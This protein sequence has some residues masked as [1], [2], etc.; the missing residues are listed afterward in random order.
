MRK[1]KIIVN[2]IAGR[3]SGEASI[4]AIQKY[5]NEYQLDFELERTEHPGHAIEIAYR[6]ASEDYYAVVAVGGDGTANEVLNGLVQV[7]NE[8]NK[9][10]TFGLIS[11]GR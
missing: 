1:Y 9:T 5:F 11:V 7:K 8:L 6:A 10:K 2:P 3:G 4:P